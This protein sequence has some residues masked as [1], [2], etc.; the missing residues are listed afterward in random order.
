MEAA[1]RIQS[2]SPAVKQ[3]RFW[4]LTRLFTGRPTQTAGPEQNRCPDWND[5]RG[6]S[7]AVVGRRNRRLTTHVGL[8]SSPE[9]PGTAPRVEVEGRIGELHRELVGAWP[10]VCRRAR[11][12]IAEFAEVAGLPWTAPSSSATADRSARPQ[13][14]PRYRAARST[15][16]S[17]RTVCRSVPPGRR[18]LPTTRSPT[19][20]GVAAVVARRRRH[21]CIVRE[22]HRQPTTTSGDPAP[23]SP[24]RV[25]ILSPREA[26]RLSICHRL[27][28]RCARATTL[29]LTSPGAR[30]C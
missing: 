14:C 20:R 8:A 23:T 5:C 4:T 21:A 11:A 27:A 1:C 28:R 9:R 30:T 15:A 2:V 3:R 19:S 25:G 17:G 7:R 26:D 18:Q 22:G 16:P 10:V 13:G 12:A 6:W 29:L 24:R